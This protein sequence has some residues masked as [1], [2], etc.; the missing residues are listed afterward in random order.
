M[1]Q[2]LPESWIY[3]HFALILMITCVQVLVIYILGDSSNPPAGLG[4]F[5]VYFMAAL[6][7]WIA[8]TLQQG[9]GSHMTVDVPSVAVIINTYILFLA[10]GQRSGVRKGRYLLGSICLLAVLSGLALPQEQMFIVQV[11][12]TTLFFVAAGLLCAQ[13]GYALGNLGDGILS[14]AS[15]IMLLS[16]PVVLYYMLVKED[17]LYAQ[18]VALGSYSAAY[19]L[20]AIGFLISVLIEYQGHLAQLATHDPLSKVYNRRGMDEALQLS[21]AAAQRRDLSTSA[22]MVDIDH[23]NQIND[24]FGPEVGDHLI[25]KIATILKNMSRSSD[26]VARVDGKKFMLVLPETKLDPAKILAERIRLAI[27]ERQLL[28]AEQRI[29][30]TASVGVTTIR[31]EITLDAL[32]READQALYLAKQ[33]GRNQVASIDHDLVHLSNNLAGS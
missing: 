12:A 14:L 30:V 8:F 26:V 7:G 17:R 18:G 9:T 13:R 33:S 28:V 23:F 15:I 16:L 22:I 32:S 1:E 6:L 31:G 29:A 25:R 20:V 2:L 11:S 27:G 19:V 4:M 10:A 5:T 21:L 3:M 24:S